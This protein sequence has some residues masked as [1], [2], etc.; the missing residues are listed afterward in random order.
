LFKVHAVLHGWKLQNDFFKVPLFKRLICGIFWLATFTNEICSTSY[1]TQ[2][3]SLKEL[4]KKYMQNVKNHIK[5]LI[6]QLQIW[7]VMLI[8]T[9]RFSLRFEMAALRK[10]KNNTSRNYKKTTV[11]KKPKRSNWATYWMLEHNPTQ[12]PECRIQFSWG[13]KSH[14]G[15]NIFSRSMHNVLLLGQN[16][17]YYIVFFYHQNSISKIKLATITFTW[18]RYWPCLTRKLQ[19]SFFNAARSRVFFN[20]GCLTSHP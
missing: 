17:F 4:W 6:I 3:S 2:T 9:W 13:Q 12:S 7:S 11:V 1:I 10:I 14:S 20:P 16:F 5:N 19:W 8:H 15:G 18:D